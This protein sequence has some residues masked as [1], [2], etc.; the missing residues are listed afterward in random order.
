MSKARNVHLM[1]LRQGDLDALCGVYAI[2]N[3]LQ[4]LLPKAKDTDYL[5][6]LFDKIIGAIYTIENLGRFRFALKERDLRCRELKTTLTAFSTYMRGGRR[7]FIQ[8]S[9][10]SA[11]LR[12]RLLMTSSD[13]EQI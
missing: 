10:R 11:S 1:P 5:T 12:T 3:A 13:R 2:L 6:N 7:D 4:W 8:R 9:V